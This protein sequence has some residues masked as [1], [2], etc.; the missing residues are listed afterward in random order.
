MTPPVRPLDFLSLPSVQHA[1]QKT[2]QFLNPVQNILADRSDEELAPYYERMAHALVQEHGANQ[3]IVGRKDIKVGG[4]RGDPVNMPGI[5]M[6]QTLLHDVLGIPDP[7]KYVTAGVVNLLGIGKDTQQIG[8]GGTPL[9]ITDPAVD[10]GDRQLNEYERLLRGFRY[11]G[12]TLRHSLTSPTGIP[13]TAGV[14]RAVLEGKLAAPRSKQ[15]QLVTAI[16]PM[17]AGLGVFAPLGFSAAGESIAT[18]LGAAAPGTAGPSTVLGGAIGRELFPSLAGGTGFDALLGGLFGA[19]EVQGKSALGQDVTPGEVVKDIG[20]YA[21]GGAAA[22]PLMAGAGKILGAVDKPQ[23]ITRIM[24]FFTKTAGARTPIQQARALSALE[25]LQDEGLVSPAARAELGD[26]VA[27]KTASGRTVYRWKPGS[28]NHDPA[29]PNKFAPAPTPEEEATIAHQIVDKYRQQIERTA[30]EATADA[31]PPPEDMAARQQEATVI[32]ALWYNNQAATLDHTAPEVLDGQLQML[33]QIVGDQTL[34]ANTRLTAYGRQLALE[35]KLGRSAGTGAGTVPI[36]AEALAIETVRRNRPVV[37]EQGLQMIAGRYEDAGDPMMAE[38]VRF[39]AKSEVPEREHG[40]V[41]KELNKLSRVARK[42][43]SEGSQAITKDGQ[44]V[45]IMTEPDYGRA[46]VRDISQEKAEPFY[47]GTEELHPMPKPRTVLRTT[48][49]RLVRVKTVSPEKGQFT[50]ID[51]ATKEPVNLTFA[52]IAE[53]TDRSGRRRLTEEELGLHLQKK[54]I[55]DTQPVPATPAVIK[56]EA[57]TVEEIGSNAAKVRT[58]SGKVKTVPRADLER[59]T[60]VRPQLQELLDQATAKLDAQPIVR[61][62]PQ[63]SSVEEVRATQAFNKRLRSSLSERT[64]LEEMFQRSADGESGLPPALV[65]ALKQVDDLGFDTPEHAAAAILQHADWRTRWDVAQPSARSAANTISKWKAQVLGYGE[66]AATEVAAG[67][68]PRQLA[69]TVTHV[70]RDRDIAAFSPMTT[71]EPGNKILF[72]NVAKDQVPTFEQAYHAGPLTP[73]TF[74]STVRRKTGPQP[75]VHVLP[76][77]ASGNTVLYALEAPGALIPMKE[78][79]DLAKS[80]IGALGG[81]ERMLTYLSPVDLPADALAA[82]RVYRVPEELHAAAQ[83]AREGLQGMDQTAQTAYLRHLIAFNETVHPQVAAAAIPLRAAAEAEVEATATNRPEQ[84]LEARKER[85]KA[86]VDAA[87]AI[88]QEQID[89][90]DPGDALAQQL[91]GLRQRAK[92]PVQGATPEDILYAQT[93]DRFIPT[94]HEPVAVRRPDGKVFGGDDLE[95]AMHKAVGGHI[96]AWKNI[97]NNDISGWGVMARRGEV[98]RGFE[99]GYQN[100]SGEFITD[101]EHA[102]ALASA[103]PSGPQADPPTAAAQDFIQKGLTDDT[104][105]YYLDELKALVDA[106]REV[107]PFERIQLL[108]A[109]DPELRLIVYKVRVPEITKAGKPT[110]TT[111]WRAEP[112]LANGRTLKEGIKE[113]GSPE[114]LVQHITDGG[115]VA[116]LHK[117]IRADY[118]HPTDPDIR[119]TIIPIGKEYQAVIEVPSE[120]ALKVLTEGP[121]TTAGKKAKAPQNLSVLIGRAQH[122]VGSGATLTQQLNR[123]VV[124]SFA[125]AEQ[126]LNQHGLEEN[127]DAKIEDSISLVDLF[128]KFPTIEDLAQGIAAESDQGIF[129]TQRGR[130]QDIEDVLGKLMSRYIQVDRHIPTPVREYAERFADLYTHVLERAPF[131]RELRFALDLPSI[132]DLGPAGQKGVNYSELAGGLPEGVKYKKGWGAPAPDI[133]KPGDQP[134]VY[135]V[136]DIEGETITPLDQAQLDAIDQQAG[137]LGIPPEVFAPEGGLDVKPVMHIHSDDNMS[138]VVPK[139]YYKLYGKLLGYKS[140]PSVPD[141][142]AAAKIGEM[143]IEQERMAPTVLH[144][145]NQEISQPGSAAGSEGRTLGRY[146]PTG[147]V[148]EVLEASP[149]DPTMRVKFA[150]EAPIDIATEDFEPSRFYHKDLSDHTFAQHIADGTYQDYVRREPEPGYGREER[151]MGLLGANPEVINQAFQTRAAEIASEIHIAENGVPTGNFEELRALY[152]RAL[153]LDN[154][155]VKSAG[156]TVTVPAETTRAGRPVEPGT[157]GQTF[158]GKAREFVPRRLVSEGILDTLRSIDKALVKPFKLSI[159]HTIRQELGDSPLAHLQAKAFM[160]ALS[161]KHVQLLRTWGNE[162]GLSKDMPTARIVAE[163]VTR[164]AFDPHAARVAVEL[165]NDAG[166]LRWTSALGTLDAGGG[167]EPLPVQLRFSRPTDPGMGISLSRPWKLLSRMPQSKFLLDG[168]GD[169]QTQQSRRLLGTTEFIA[170]MFQHG[171]KH[172]DWLAARQLIQRHPNWN[173][174]LEAGASPKLEYLFNGLKERMALNKEDLIRQALRSGVNAIQFDPKN[175]QHVGWLNDL[176]IKPESIDQTNFAFL[177]REIDLAKNWQGVEPHPYWNHDRIEEFLS[178]QRRYKS[179]ADLPGDTSDEMRRVFDLWKRYGIENYWPLIHEG[180]RAVIVVS[181]QGEER[182]VAWT[183]SHIDAL[184]HIEELTRQGKINPTDNVKIRMRETV[185]DDI[186]VKLFKDVKEWKQIQ[187]MF[188]EAGNV[189][190]AQALLLRAD[191]PIPPARARRG[192]QVHLKERTLDLQ[193]VVPDP[194]HELTLYEGRLAR[195]EYRYNVSQSFRLFQDRALDRAMANRY[196]L[197]PLWRRDGKANYEN[198][199]SYAEDYVRSALGQQNKFE[200]WQDRLKSLTQM[201]SH[202]PAFTVGKLVKEFRGGEYPLTLQEIWNPG[203]YFRK[204]GARESSSAAVALQS[205]LKLSFSPMSALANS[206]QFLIN[207]YPKLIEKGFNEVQATALAFDAWK[208]AIKIWGSG[209]PGVKRL[210]GTLGPD[211]AREVAL[212]ERAGIALVP[213]KHMAGESAMGTVS[214]QIPRNIGQGALKLSGQWFKYTSMLGFNGAESVNRYATGLVAIRRALQKGMSEE[215]AIAG[216]RR[217]V[218][219]TQF[220]YDEL[221]LPAVMRNMGPVGRVLLQFKPFVVNMLAYEKDLA[222]NALRFNGTTSANVAWR[223]LGAHVAGIAL[224]GGA[225]GLMYHPAFTLLGKT[226]KLFTGGRVNHVAGIPLTV[227]DLQADRRAQ[228]LAMKTPEE[229]FTQTLHYDWDD[230]LLYG[231]PGLA[232]LN[233]GQRVGVSGQDLTFG[234]NASSLLG[235]HFGAQYEFISALGKYITSPDAGRGT[236]GAAAGALLPS[237][238]PGS[239]GRIA[240]TPFGRIGGAY[241]G[242][243]VASLGS[244]NDFGKFLFG[245]RGVAGDESPA[246]RALM[247]RAYPVALRNAMWT[248]ELHNELMAR[249]IDGKPM[250]IPAANRAEE[251]LYMMASAPTIRRSE[252]A[253][254]VSMMVG[255][256]AALAATRQSYV[257][258]IARAR[259][260]GTEAGYIEANKLILRASEQGVSIS[261]SSIQREVETLTNERI[262][263][264][265]QQQPASTRWARP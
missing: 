145:L 260:A 89:A 9:D 114:Q 110:T 212:M 176:G 35:S 198:L 204:Y 90:H 92:S 42:G 139:D 264:I 17:L 25:M 101:A 56:G 164:K 179:S 27:H 134:G 44:I 85:I 128:R 142:E 157:G 213:G 54:L 83:Q 219:E 109:N 137:A 116:G 5:T 161:D 195:G 224:F 133:Q 223:Q 33:K 111:L 200:V 104:K 194:I 216:A 76:Q 254:A 100:S 174:A 23:F 205:M 261:E 245:Q 30:P 206:T 160:G 64:A 24:D 242:A 119:G 243:G 41:M 65:K 37:G 95:D 57:V 67:A 147:Q 140:K 149:A 230:L 126:F 58:R 158:V 88:V 257:D 187:H 251:M 131:S 171:Y 79:S 178:L 122:E 193:P 148:V 106:P 28:P 203:T 87:Q 19:S 238:I 31:A 233:L 108:N 211:L 121:V 221:S 163:L 1:M 107:Q 132:E 186:V 6:L 39:W 18:R 55:D 105:T 196:G 190:N 117:S 225:T 77:E 50:G 2:D 72:F 53:V 62:V 29:N 207:T 120:R 129:L 146:K 215:A 81:K 172:T 248:W 99:K 143:M 123:K 34:P 152:R 75:L 46:L 235:P 231:V 61:E 244:Y 197:E 253:A 91:E 10:V 48:D 47:V 80:A 98:P 181:P 66:K 255:D 94:A 220:N 96:N 153:W 71:P 22:R 237:L 226:I 156:R 8:Q 263:T 59:S 252:Y 162:L 21:L 49:G 36:E 182:L 199:V 68:A 70:V 112:T 227:E 165:Q 259:A 3:T 86:S 183:Q 78:Y 40:E 20:G 180:N 82:A 73:E 7:T 210:G 217:L 240:R 191:A 97:A 14:E 166:F 209:L 249:D 239:V 11:F 93:G 265:R 4:I 63:G 118:I 184:N 202:G 136:P 144:A 208:D 12:A 192:R 69:P 232:H 159:Y 13:G 103:K 185:D 16:A 74:P 175:P 141:V 155:D 15:E 214:G 45:E 32:G 135:D 177:P 102:A 84:A 154:W 113:F 130:L 258:R 169:A 124:S 229:A 43:F 173:A 127:L 250:H 125:E 38:R 246:G 150:G 167:G 51:A 234:A 189:D 256:G 170:D 262:E 26:R 236:A 188:I 151:A 222:M 228:R 201:L 168:I 241:L 247:S 52:D 115:Y 60:E 218:R 138:R